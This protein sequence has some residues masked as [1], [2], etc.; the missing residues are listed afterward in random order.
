MQTPL[1]TPAQIVFPPSARRMQERFGSRSAYAKRDRPE[2][3]FPREV[4]EE[5]AAFLAELDS[6]FIA[7]ATPDGHPYIQ[8]RGGPK[9]F[10]KVLGPTMLA[11]ADFAGNRQYITIGRL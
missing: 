11:F 6:F 5:L 3:G 10:L 2:T 1:E 4:D 7:T 9:G 8:H